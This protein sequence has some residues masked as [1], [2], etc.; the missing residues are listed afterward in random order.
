LT[1]NEYRRGSVVRRRTAG[2]YALS[3][4][5]PAI[6]AAYSP[7]L[8]PDESPTDLLGAPAK[9]AAA[10]GLLDRVASSSGPCPRSHAPRPRCDHASGR[11]R[12]QGEEGPHAAGCSTAIAGA[13]ATVR[14]GLPTSPWRGL[15]ARRLR[16]TV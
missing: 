6:D 14:A 12:L 1:P 11:P 2:N 8:A 4:G 3:D 15:R 9:I 5:S 10:E 16:T 7:P 13:A